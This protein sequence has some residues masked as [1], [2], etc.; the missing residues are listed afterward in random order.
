MLDCSKLSFNTDAFAIEIQCDKLAKRSSTTIIE[1][2]DPPLNSSFHEFADRFN[3]SYYI[4]RR[5]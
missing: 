4:H 1:E 2:F 5:I 3:Q